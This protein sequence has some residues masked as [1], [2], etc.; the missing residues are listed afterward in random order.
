LLA[1][2]A[3][4]ALYRLKRGAAWQLWAFAQVLI[5]PVSSLTIIISPID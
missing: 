4:G 1:I 5:E 3:I 2:S